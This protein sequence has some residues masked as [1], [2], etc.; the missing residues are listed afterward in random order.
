MWAA[1]RCSRQSRRDAAAALV[2]CQRR[3]DAYGWLAMDSW[4]TSA[5]ESV[6]RMVLQ[7]RAEQEYQTSRQGSTTTT[8]ARARARERGAHVR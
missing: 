8:R 1:L 7:G 3:T 6:A 2:R 5:C 4:S